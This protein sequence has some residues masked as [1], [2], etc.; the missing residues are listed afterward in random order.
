MRLP[1]ASF[2]ACGAREAPCRRT[3]PTLPLRAARG[4]P[5]LDADATAARA[6]SSAAEASTGTRTDPPATT[7]APLGS[8]ATS[9]S[10]TGSAACSASRATAHSA[11]EAARASAPTS[12]AAARRHAAPAGGRGSSTRPPARGSGGEGRRSTNRSPLAAAT[13]TSRRRMAV[14]SPP[15]SPSTSR[16]PRR[17]TP[18][19]C[20]VPRWSR[21]AVPPAS[22]EAE[23]GPG[24]PSRTDRR[25]ATSSRSV[26]TTVGSTAS[27]LP[28]RMAARS[29]PARLAARRPPGPPA[30]TTAPRTCSSRG[31]TGCP[32]GSSRSDALRCS[33]PPRSVPVTTVP[34][35]RTPKTRSTASRAGP[36]APAPS[37]RARSRR[38]TRATRRSSSPVP[39]VDE[40]DRIGAPASVVRSTRARTRFET[41]ESRSGGTRSALVTATTAVDQPERVEELEMLQ[42]LGPRTVV[43]GHHEQH[44]VDLARPDEHVANQPIV[45]WNVHEIEHVAIREGQ[46]RIPDLDRHP[47]ATLLGQPVG[48]DPRERP[49]QRRL[50]VVDVAR[51][52]DDDGHPRRSAVPRADATP[53]PS[54]TS[55]A[56]ST[57]RRS[58]TTRPPSIRPTTAGSPS[59]K[60]AKEPVRGHAGP[61]VEGEPEG[62][63]RLARQRAT[64][65]GCRQRDG[66]RPVHPGCQGVGASAQRLDRRCDH[67]PDRDLGS[68]PPSPVEAERGRDSGQRHLVRPHRPSQ[69]ILPKSRDQVGP[70]DDQPGLRPPDEL[71]TREEDQVGARRRGVRPASARVRARTRRCRAGRRIRGRPPPGHRGHGPAR[72]AEPGPAPR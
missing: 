12:E 5:A 54:S 63:Q 41:V 60:A 42:R 72:R 7:P 50:A 27:T 57:V 51:R 66:P 14:N 19:D 53:R 13:G 17:I 44:G 35:P 59:R 46:M 32:P 40:T 31:R 52:P 49:E 43:G 61:R 58:R 28:R 4:R 30:S 18:D 8:T 55:A 6:S 2:A 70:P 45:A 21:I 3:R 62:R 10:F 71:V 65:E 1:A 20:A 68:R 16:R 67:P 36:G 64:A 33:G 56:G 69:G 9:G 34:R 22:G 15:A 29:A 11:G 24:S 47:A 37:R 25:S 39:S 26:A 23:T 48:V 38:S